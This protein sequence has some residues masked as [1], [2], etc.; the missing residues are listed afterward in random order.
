MGISRFS[1][2]QI[3]LFSLWYQIMICLLYL[4]MISRERLWVSPLPNYEP[5]TTL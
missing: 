2:T 3:D 5:R 1:V 4:K